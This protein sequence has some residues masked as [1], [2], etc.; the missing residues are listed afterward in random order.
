MST[1]KLKMINPEVM[2]SPNRTSVMVRCC[3]FGKMSPIMKAP[4]VKEI[5]FD[6]RKRTKKRYGRS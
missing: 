6:D 3:F 2:N 4:K 1:A 5:D